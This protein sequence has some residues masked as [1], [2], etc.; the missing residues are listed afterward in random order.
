MFL[1]TL[2]F[3]DALPQLWKVSSLQTIIFTFFCIVGW[4]H[5]LFAL[6]AVGLCW[7]DGCHFTWHRDVPR[8]QAL[9]ETSL[10]CQ[11]VPV[12]LEKC[13]QFVPVQLIF[14]VCLDLS[15]APWSRDS[16]KAGA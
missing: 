7:D 2:A 4:D 12:A 1:L 13:P 14:V 15:P 3:V 9:H 10:R 16:A 6:N 11:A 8:K 5:P